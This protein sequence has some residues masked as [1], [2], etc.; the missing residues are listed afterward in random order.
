MIPNEHRAD[1][2]QSGLQF[3][4]SI[5]EAYGPEEGLRLWDTIASTL[6]PDVKAQVF[7]AMITGQYTTTIVIPAQQTPNRVGAIKAIRSVTGLGLKE[8]KDLSDEM[9]MKSI[10]LTVEPDQRSKAINTLRDSG[11]H[12]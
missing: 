12:L 10:K 9:Q 11:I 1:V 2:I 5:T 3:M 4:R 7:F 6:D 8:A